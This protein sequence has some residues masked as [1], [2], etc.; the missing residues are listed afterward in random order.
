MLPTPSRGTVMCWLGCPLGFP[1]RFWFAPNFGGAFP[2]RTQDRSRV[3]R[4]GTV[5]AITLA[6]SSP[7]SR[8][9][10]ARRAPLPLRP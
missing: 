10:R 9:V 7:M 5:A 3:G 6:A 4:V 1:L 8:T 2:Q